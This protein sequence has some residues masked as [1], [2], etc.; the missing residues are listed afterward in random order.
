MNKDHI[1][2]NL[3]IIKNRLLSISVKGRD[4]LALA[5]AIAGIEHTQRL[6][7]AK[8]EQQETT[9]DNKADSSEEQGGE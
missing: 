8:E 6:L 4:V 7:L 9:E 1:N 3:N 2:Q 5:D